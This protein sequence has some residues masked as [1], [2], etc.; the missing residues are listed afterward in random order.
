VWCQPRSSFKLALRRIHSSSWRPFG[1][2]VAA[3]LDES[4]AVPQPVVAFRT[5]RNRAPSNDDLGHAI[6]LGEHLRELLPYVDAEFRIFSPSALTNPTADSAYIR[7]AALKLRHGLG[8]ADTDPTTLSH[9]L[10]LHRQAGSL[11]VPVLWG[12]EKV[13][14]ENALSVYLPE[15]KAS[16]VLFNLNCKIDDFKYWLA[17]EL[18]HCYT[19]HALRDEPGED[20]SEE[21]ARALLCPNAMEEQCW[22]RV[23]Q[24][25]AKQKEAFAI[26]S[27]LEMS[28]ITVVN[29]IESYAKRAGVAG[30]GVGKF[31]MARWN[32]T[33]H[34]M[35][36]VAQKL[37]GTEAPDTRTYVAAC[38]DQFRTPVFRAIARWQEANGKSP[39]FVASALNIGLADA[40]AISDYASGGASPNSSL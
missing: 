40:K 27:E 11:L 26:A 31:L 16:W 2:D 3:L 13:G 22:K 14:H 19:L 39:S 28:V 21:F 6:V 25:S 7:A 33:R 35:P 32:S 8:L 29:G 15:S 37:F 10:L 23:H 9:L 34:A 30:A 5:R 20:F 12:G 38:E 1:L 24:S 4:E 36:S 18:G 17:H